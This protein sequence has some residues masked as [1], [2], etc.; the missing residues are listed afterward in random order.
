LEERIKIK[1]TQPYYYPNT[2]WGYQTPQLT[3]YQT[4]TT[5]EIPVKSKEEAYYYPVALGGKMR[6]RKEDGSCLYVKTMGT[7]VTEPFRFEE[8][9]RKVTEEPTPIDNTTNKYDDEIKKLWGEINALKTKQNNSQS[10]S[11]NKDNGG[12]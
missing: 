8:Y 9:E 10:N 2:G 1:M 12:N 3:G 6:F 11:K 7:S 4:Q 5:D